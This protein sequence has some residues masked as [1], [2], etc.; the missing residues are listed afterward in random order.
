[1]ANEIQFDD[2]ACYER[3]MGIWSRIVG[4]EFLSWLQPEPSQRWLDVGC[5]N[6]AF[7]ELV[8]QGCSPA[9][10]HGIDSSLAQIAYAAQRPG[11]AGAH[12]MAGDA[13]QIPFEADRFNITASALVLFFIPDPV[14]AVA[15]MVR[16]TK[17]G[18]IVCAYV[19]DVLGGGLPNSPIATELRNDGIEIP[20]P[21]TS[22]ISRASALMDLFRTGGGRRTSRC[23]ASKRGARSRTSTIGGA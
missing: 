3:I 17:P 16:V 11:A 14:K 8:M 7:T 12:F 2:G 13:M 4:E 10:M 15:E 6:G 19:W 1:M 20:L 9:S 21:P 18:G 22:S 23:A 5:G